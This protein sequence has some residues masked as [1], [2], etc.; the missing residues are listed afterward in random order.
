MFVVLPMPTCPYVLSPT[1]INFV[2]VP[3]AES[4][5]VVVAVSPAAM[6]ITEVYTAR[7]LAADVAATLLE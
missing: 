1:Q 6:D 3:L 7:Q 2:E 5:Q 4:T